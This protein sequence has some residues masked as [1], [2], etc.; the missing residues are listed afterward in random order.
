MGQ[1]NSTGGGS[2]ATRQRASRAV[3]LN[4]FTRPLA[5]A[6]VAIT[7]IVAALT[8]WWW[9]LLIGAAFYGFLVWSAL[10]DA[11]LTAQ[12]VSEELYPERK[13]DLGKLSGP[14]RDAVQRALTA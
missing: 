8:G 5:A 12:V 14:Y 3:L 2:P 9:F 1:A 4:A 10:S 11:Q 7:I 6:T 13:L